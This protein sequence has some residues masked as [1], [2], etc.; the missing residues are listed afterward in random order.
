MNY[1]RELEQECEKLK[2]GRDLDTKTSSKLPSGDI[3]KKKAIT[4]G[5]VFT[6]L[7]STDSRTIA[8]F[9]YIKYRFIR[10][11]LRTLTFGDPKEYGKT[12]PRL[13]LWLIFM[14][15]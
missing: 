3:L 1:L 8:I 6:V 4:V 10:V 7:F 2:V 12:L 5:K 15:C 14:G 11:Y 9:I 13:H